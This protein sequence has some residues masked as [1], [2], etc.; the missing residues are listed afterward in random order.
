MFE[1]PD[2]EIVDTHQHFVFVDRFQYYWMSSM[3][4]SMHRNFTPAMSDKVMDEAGVRSCVVVQAVPAVEETDALVEA[5]QH[6]PRIRAVVGAIDLTHSNVRDLLE[7]YSKR[8]LVRSVRH[9]TAEDQGPNWFLRPEVLRGFSA[10]ERSGLTCDLLCG[11]H[12]LHTVAELAD[13]FP[14]LRIVLEHAGK[15][16]IREREFDKWSR[17]IGTLS[18][19]ENVC[20]KISELLTLAD[21]ESW[22]V[23][24]VRPYLHRCVEVFGYERLMW[25]SGWPVCLV[26]SPYVE[27]LTVMMDNLPGAGPLD[28]YK[29]FRSNA[30]KWYALNDSSTERER[31]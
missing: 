20:C 25:G 12:Q 14:S 9:Q 1:S 28:V 22:S 5:A 6:S 8:P 23:D 15:P 3:P 17:A 7:G 26:A 16:R 30:L 19:R 18:S 21:W 2:F 29:V 11:C 4:A 24:S 13:R 10:V 27:T 31:E